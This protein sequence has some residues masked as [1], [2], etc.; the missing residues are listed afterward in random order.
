MNKITLIVCFLLLNVSLGYS[1]E[2][3]LS[4]AR[5]LGLSHASVSLYDVWS[6]VNNQA[7][8]A[9]LEQASVAVFYE[10][11]FNLE[12]LETISGSFVFPMA[13][14][15]F[16]ANYYQFGKGTYKE[17][18]IGISFAKRLTERLSAALQLDYFSLRMP[19]NTKAFQTF[20]FEG[21]VLF[22]VTKDL[23]LGAHI[24]NPV[25][26]NIKTP[27]GEIDLPGMVRLGGHYHFNKQTLLAIEFEKDIKNPLLIKTGFEFLPVKN[28]A[29]RFGI[30][31][32]PVK[33]SAGMGY[34]FKNITTDFGFSYH[35]NLGLTPSVSMQFSL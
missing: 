11:R 1:I 15:T 18:K 33:F 19:E 12:M 13:P 7:G 4:G 29:F 21:G 9:F 30:S 6:N 32:K 23:F 14:G 24:I 34:S 3:Q 16:G 20:T 31:G 5:S 26:Q 35:G 8:L 28:L 22:S 17:S 27:V 10:S 25:L 2:N